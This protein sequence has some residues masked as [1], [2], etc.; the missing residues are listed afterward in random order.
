MAWN[1]FEWLDNVAEEENPALQIAADHA[2]S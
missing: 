2:L 1:F